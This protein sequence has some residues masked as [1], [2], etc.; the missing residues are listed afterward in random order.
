MNELICVSVCSFVSVCVH[1]YVCVI[2]VRVWGG[3]CVCVCVCVDLCV[4]VC[5][6]AH[7]ALPLRLQG[8]EHHD[9]RVVSGRGL[10]EAP[11]LVSVHADHGA[12]GGP[13]HQLLHLLRQQVLRGTPG[14]SY[15]R[16]STS[17]RTLRF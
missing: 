8:G 16:A 11:E 2:S 1:L 5:V 12:S 15:Q 17:L 6:P 13:L 3:L 10:D 4:F 14:G 7:G 9:D